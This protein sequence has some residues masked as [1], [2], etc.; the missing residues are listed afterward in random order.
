MC[1]VQIAR[2]VRG[3]LL[4]EETQVKTLGLPCGQR[5]RSVVAW[6]IS[7]MVWVDMSEGI[8]VGAGSSGWKLTSRALQIK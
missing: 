5:E 7:S 3:M 8:L 4:C 6:G 1:R 2:G